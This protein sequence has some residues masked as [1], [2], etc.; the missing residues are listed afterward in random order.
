MKDFLKNLL[1]EIRPTKQKDSNDELKRE[2]A[3]LY[4][5]FSVL[6]GSEKVILKACKMEALELMRSEAVPKK[7][8]ALKKTG[9]RESDN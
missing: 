7:V 6:G 3:S 2:V 1:P 4:N 5:M 8:L 9:T